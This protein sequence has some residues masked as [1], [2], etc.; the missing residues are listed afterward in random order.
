MSEGKKVLP[1]QLSTAAINPEC[2]FV[3]LLYC[4]Y[5]QSCFQTV[6]AAEIH[7]VEF[8]CPFYSHIY[9]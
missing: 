5:I 4:V 6:K 2:H 7:S 8:V 9:F 3:T 1:V